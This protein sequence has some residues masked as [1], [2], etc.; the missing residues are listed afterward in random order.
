MQERIFAPRI[1]HFGGAEEGVFFACN[2]LAACECGGMKEEE[3]G[4]KAP[5]LKQNLT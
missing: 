5:T 3:E 4:S 1:I 2:T